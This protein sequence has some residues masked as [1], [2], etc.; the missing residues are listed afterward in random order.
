MGLTGVVAE[1]SAL[2]DSEGEVGADHSLEV[3]EATDDGAVIPGIVVRQGSGIMV[4]RLP[5]IG[6]SV[7]C[8]DVAR[9]DVEADHFEDAFDH[10]GLFECDGTIGVASETGTEVVFEFP[11]VGEVVVGLEGSNFGADEVFVGAE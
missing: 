1:A 5:G 7:M 3:A 2:L 10:A 8:F 9:G 4:K 11:V 6:R